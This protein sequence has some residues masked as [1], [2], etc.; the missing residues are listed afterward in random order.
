MQ[1]TLTHTLKLTALLLTLFFTNFS[2]KEKEVP[3]VLPVIEALPITQIMVGPPSGPRN[4]FTSN[5]RVL[6]KE[7]GN[8]K[9][10]EYGI[11]FSTYYSSEILNNSP[12]LWKVPTLQTHGPHIITEE[13]EVGERVMSR[14]NNYP[15]RTHAYQR[16]YAKLEDDRIIYSD[17]IFTTHE[18]I[19]TPY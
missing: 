9:V 10:I 3:Q 4:S 15:L 2:C 1:K 12:Y 18:K 11:L 14:D 6:V 19:A 13:F 5:Y 8:V 17:V 16:A 7:K